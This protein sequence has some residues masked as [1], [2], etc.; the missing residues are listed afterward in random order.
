VLADVEVLSMS[1]VRSDLEDVY[2][3]LGRD[4]VS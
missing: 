3:S 2:S 1:K 4:A